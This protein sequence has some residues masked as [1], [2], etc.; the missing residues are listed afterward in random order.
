MEVVEKIEQ[1]AWF[2][3]AFRSSG[4]NSTALSQVGFRVVPESSESQALMT[5]LILL[6]LR[7][8]EGIKPIYG[9]CWLSLI[10]DSVL[11]SGF[12]IKEREQA[13]GLEIPYPL[14]LNACRVQSPVEFWDSIRIRRDSLTVYPIAKHHD[15]FQWHAVVDE[16]ERGVLYHEL[17]RFPLL[18]VEMKH[19]NPIFYLRTFVG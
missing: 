14:F 11:A 15:W 8:Y 16:H 9:S 13:V 6:P 7:S 10:P 18:P 12:P 17:T 2:A 4:E 19:D 1:F 3:S 5:E